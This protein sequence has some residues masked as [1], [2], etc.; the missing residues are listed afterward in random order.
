M[1]IPVGNDNQAALNLVLPLRSWAGL[2]IV[3]LISFIKTKAL[4]EAADQV[5]TLHFLRLVD[6]GAD[7]QLGFFTAYDGDFRKYIEDFIRCLA[8]VFDAVFKFVANAPPLPVAK[9]SDEFIDWIADHNVES[10]GFYSAYPAMTVQDILT[11]YSGGAATGK[12]TQ[13]ALT[14]PL[15]IKTPANFLAMSQLLPSALPK[16][17]ETA[18]RLGNLHFARFIPLSSTKLMFVC[19]YDGAEADLVRSFARELGPV[20][21]SLLEHVVDA[22]PSPVR[23]NVEAF[24][25]WVAARNKPTSLYYRGYPALKVQDVKAVA[26]TAAA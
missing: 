14:L 3:K 25:S 22:P 4:Y 2:N 23:D 8:P 13:S 24:V 26:A 21:D 11:R 19:D 7:N 16:L 5:G 10:I 20:F 17:F 15:P 18:D 12:G 9:H 6:L 1:S